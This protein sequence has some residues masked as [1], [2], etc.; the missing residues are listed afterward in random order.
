MYITIYAWF[1]G[2]KLHFTEININIL[3]D[4]INSKQAVDLIHLFDK[5]LNF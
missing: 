1:E 5:F 4:L 2:I 3:L